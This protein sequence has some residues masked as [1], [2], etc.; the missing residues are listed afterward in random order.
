MREIVE[1]YTDSL[2]HLG[3]G[4]K[5]D[6]RNGYQMRDKESPRC[7]TLEVLLCFSPVQFR[8]VLA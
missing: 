6:E 1:K 2:L 7:R 3:D 5:S 4:V 8:P